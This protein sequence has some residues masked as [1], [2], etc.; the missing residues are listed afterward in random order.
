MSCEAARHEAQHQGWRILREESAE[1]KDCVVVS[2]YGMNNNRMTLADARAYADR[3][4]APGTRVMRL[5]PV[6]GEK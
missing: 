5:V 4:E 1:A 2:D 6:E 3:L